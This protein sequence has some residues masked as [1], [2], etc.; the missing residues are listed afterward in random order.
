M[1]VFSLSILGLQLAFDGRLMLPEIGGRL[2][3]FEGLELIEDRALR[4]LRSRR[5]A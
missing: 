1:L 5:A 3:A 2:F 4:Y